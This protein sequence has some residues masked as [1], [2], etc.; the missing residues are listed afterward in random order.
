MEAQIMCQRTTGEYTIESTHQVTIFPSIRRLLRE[1][2]SVDDRFKPLNFHSSVKSPVRVR[3]GLMYFGDGIC[4]GDPDVR[5]AANQDGLKL[6][7]VAGLLSM[8]N[9]YPDLQFSKKIASLEPLWVDA[10]MHCHAVYLHAG[11]P[12]KCVKFHEV[13]LG[14]TGGYRFAAILPPFPAKLF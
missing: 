10:Q 4:V 12:G 6:L 14:W 8:G 9:Q 2:N 11:P 13:R 7:D 1:Y 3:V 5:K